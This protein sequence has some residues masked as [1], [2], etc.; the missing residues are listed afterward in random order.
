MPAVQP[1]R[2][3]MVSQGYSAERQKRQAWVHTQ[4]CLRVGGRLSDFGGWVTRLYVGGGVVKDGS[5]SGVVIGMA[6]LCGCCR[7]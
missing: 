2:A 4:C 1:Q 5:D 7:G 6:S 3:T